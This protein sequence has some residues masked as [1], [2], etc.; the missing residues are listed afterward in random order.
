M[1]FQ[2]SPFALL[3]P[4]SFPCSQPPKQPHRQKQDG[5]WSAG[6]KE[7]LGVMGRGG[8]VPQHGEEKCPRGNADALPGH[9]TAPYRGKDG[10]GLLNP[11]FVPSH[12]AVPGK[13]DLGVQW[14]PPT[15]YGEG[16]E[17]R[18]GGRRAS[19]AASRSKQTPRKIKNKEEEGGG[20]GGVE[21][22]EL[23]ALP[24]PPAGRQRRSRPGSSS[25]GCPVV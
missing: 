2:L 25:R 12:R 14:E 22:R 20:R 7:V 19:P 8:E 10:E 9:F 4:P 1:S 16:G 13:G 23:G 5:F 6:R 18:G 3:L 17:T 21:G 11:K 15:R 24:L